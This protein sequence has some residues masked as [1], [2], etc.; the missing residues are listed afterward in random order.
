V[1]TTSIS[2]ASPAYGQPATITV[3][4]TAGG[5]PQAGSTGTVTVGG[6]T[7]TCTTNSSGQCTVS[8]PG[9]VLQGG[10]NAVSVATSA[11]ANATAGSLSTSIAV[12]AVAAVVTA[13][14]SP[15]SP[16]YGQAATITVTATAGGIPQAGSVGTVSVGG[17]TYTCTTNSSGQCAIAVPGGV[18]QGGSDTVSATTA[19]TANAAAG[20]GSSSVTV[21]P[22]SA[23]LTST[24]SPASPVYGQAATLTVTATAGGIPQPGLMGTVTVGTQSYTCTTNSSGQCAVSILGGVLA[25]G[26]NIVALSSPATANALAGSSGGAVTVLPAPT[27]LTLSS[28]ALTITQTNAVTFTATSLST[29]IGTPTGTVTFYANGVAIGTGTLNGGVAT[30]TLSTLA[31]GSDTITAIYSGDT[32]F[33]TVTSAALTETVNIAGFTLGASG[34]G[35]GSGS[36]SGPIDTVQPGGTAMFGL[37]LGILNGFTG[38]LTMSATGLPPG[39][40]ATF[41]PEIVVLNGTTAATTTLSIVTPVTPPPATAATQW[42][43]SGSPIRYGL[44]LLPLLAIGRLG[45]QLRRTPLLL[46]LALLSLGTLS[47]GLSGCGGGYLE[48]SARSYLITVTATSGSLHQSTTVTLTVQ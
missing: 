22:A 47:I 31:T 42:P 3:T 41:T 11:T 6:Q 18:L 27:T 16:S 17:Q 4:A 48:E 2:P 9:G 44:L 13:T 1:V 40:T 43:G 8:V 14:L 39:A 7:Y 36:S 37:S 5:T 10:S 24:I 45:R 38:S 20:A 12:V 28:S 26:S 29:T 35:S 19:A 46:L 21:A 23:V 33:S 25:P 34:S 30:L 15:A 32:D